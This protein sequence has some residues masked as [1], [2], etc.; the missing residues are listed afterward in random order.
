MSTVNRS[1]QVS[2]QNNTGG[3]AVITMSHMYENQPVETQTWTIANGAVSD[4][5][6]TANYETGAG[7]GFDY[8]YCSA[9]VM[10]GPNPGTY[11]TEGSAANPTKECELEEAD[12]G[13]F[14]NTVDT[15]TFCMNQ[16]SGGCKTGMKRTG[17]YYSWIN[18]IFVLMLENHSFDHLLG[19][20]GI[21]DLNG[22]TGTESNLYNDNGSV[23][24]YTVKQPAVDP[25]TTDPNHEFQD[26]F[27]QLCG[28]FAPT[29]PKNGPYPPT[30]DFIN[31]SGFAANYATVD[32][33]HTGLP[34]LPDIGDVLACCTPDQIPAMYQL[35][36]EFAVC[37]NWFSSM[38]GPTWPNRLFAMG[39]S[40]SGL[41]DSPS[42]SQII[43]W[44]TVS[45]FKYV[46]GSLFQLISKMGLNY[47]LYNDGSDEF[48][49]NPAPFYD[50]GG[51][52]IVAAL[53]GVTM[54]IDTNDFSN[55]AN[56]LQGAYPYQFTFIE[57]NYGD[58]SGN[59]YSGGSSQ[60]PMDSL[61]A[62][63]MM[64]AATYNAIRNS[65]LWNTSLLIITYDEHGGF[66]DHVPPGPAPEPGDG[67]P[68]G[69]NTCGFQF[70][71]YGVRVPAVVVSP[72]IAKGTVNHDLF[73]HTSIAKTVESLYGLGPLT[74]RDTAANPL[75]VLLTLGTP[76]TD[77]PTQI[78]G[79]PPASFAVS[80]PVPPV[81]EADDMADPTPLPEKGNVIG[82]L[83]VAM[84]ADFEMS[85]GSDASRS[86][87]IA[88]VQGI[89]TRGQARQYF[90]EVWTK[91]QAKKAAMGTS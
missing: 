73:D 74:D 67:N 70:D 82:H 60:H 79:T 10:D 22:L 44:E 57:P 25:M 56:D 68:Y 77:C 42:Q 2:I 65:P 5:A 58:A 14:T 80:P 37:D 6:L 7:T 9:S 40:S 49:A 87:I 19:F 8:W 33:E 46:N 21:P 34:G 4:S 76:R 61:A 39:A 51:F 47:R 90:G 89:K 28:Q 45:G 15:T 13:S 78:S 52:P 53:Q 66:Y 35:A 91:V 23:T 30:G 31:N 24:T 12:A 88:R 55:F 27:Q 29:F 71:N 41:D 48:A 32:D 26:T 43:E 85:D 63:E 81:S 83:H 84:K 36:T 50:G 54:Y 3:T 20:S 75:T 38:P 1:A 86:A 64:I 59:T 11:V 72:L 69:L 16:P 17:P 18:N 62:G